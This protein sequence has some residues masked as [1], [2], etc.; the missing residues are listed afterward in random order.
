ME[1]DAVDVIAVNGCG[2]KV[3]EVNDQCIL[4]GVGGNRTVSARV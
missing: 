3:R 1:G 2:E 4:A